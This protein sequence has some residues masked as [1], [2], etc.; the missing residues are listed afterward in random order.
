MTYDT[1]SQYTFFSSI[2]KNKFK[3]IQLQFI[4]IKNQALYIHPY[5]LPH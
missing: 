2:V 4:P 5:L 3:I 1:Q